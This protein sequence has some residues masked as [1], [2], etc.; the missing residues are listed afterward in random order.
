[1]SK[2]RKLAMLTALAVMASPVINITDLPEP[3]IKVRD[4]DEFNRTKGLKK[5]FYGENSLWAIN[6][7]NADRKARSLNWL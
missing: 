4:E 7:K 5:F 3:E 6:Q 1:M 2:M